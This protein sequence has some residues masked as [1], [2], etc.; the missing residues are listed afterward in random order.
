MESSNNSSL[1]TKKGVANNIS[2]VDSKE[3]KINAM[4]D[5][6]KQAMGADTFD[7]VF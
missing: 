5:K 7:K 2:T 6:V 3:A 1:L 4:K